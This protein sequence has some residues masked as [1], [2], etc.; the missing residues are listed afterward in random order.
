[1]E[2]AELVERIK[3]AAP[4]GRYIFGGEE[5]YL[6]RYY[7]KQL[8]KTALGDEADIFSYTVFDGEDVDFDALRETIISPSLMSEYKVIEWR[9]ANFNSMKEKELLALEELAELQEDNPDTVLIF[10]AP[11]DGFDFSAGKTPSKLERRLGKCYE[12]V[13]FKKSTDRQLLGWLKRHFDAEGITVD[14]ETLSVLLDRSGRVMDVL[15]NEV[16]KLAA[17]AKAR[18]KSQITK[19]DVAEV[20]S[21]T[22][23]SETFALQNAVTNRDKTA[24]FSALEDLKFR[25]ADAGAVLSM[26]ERSFTELLLAATLQKDGEGEAA[27]NLLGLR[28]YRAKITLAGASKY[29]AERL[30]LT[31]SELTRLDA[32]SKFGGIS[33]YKLIELFISQWL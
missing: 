15:I 30:R 29:G 13:N 24:A 18:D 23:E 21:S 11:A 32:A 4:E 1:M 10:T 9:F 28:G 6:K 7:A 19:Q 22:P 20:A 8:V 25:R 17:L 2:I 3:K 14:A 26:L 5:D 33:G 31:L 27:E 16:H 12:L